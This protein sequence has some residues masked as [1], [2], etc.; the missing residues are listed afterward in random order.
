MIKKEQFDAA[1][2]AYPRWRIVWALWRAGVPVRIGA[3]SK[4][5]SIL[6]TNRIW[7]HR[8]EGKKHEADYNLELLEALGVPF[9]RYPTRFVLTEEEKK[10]R[11]KNSGI[12]SRDVYEANRHFASWIWRLFS[13]LAAG[14]LYGVGR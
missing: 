9:K 11:K 2:V 7:Q 13:S 1:I 14:S 10:P 8:S 6:F 4:P 12:A 3:A 5:Y